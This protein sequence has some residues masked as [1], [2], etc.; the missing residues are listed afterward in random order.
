MKREHY[1]ELKYIS[2]RLKRIADQIHDVCSIPSPGNYETSYNR[3]LLNLLQE[4]TE[5]KFDTFKRLED[6]ILKESG[7]NE[8]E[9]QHLTELDHEIRIANLFISVKLELR[10]QE[11]RAENSH[12]IKCFYCESKVHYV[13]SCLGFE[14]LSVHRRC[15]FL[16]EN[17]ICFKCLR[18]HI[19]PNCTK[20][21]LCK[22]CGKDNH[23]TLVHRLWV[24]LI[25]YMIEFT[26]VFDLLSYKIKALKAELFTIL[27]RFNRKCCRQYFCCRLLFNEVL[28][29]FYNKR[30]VSCR[31]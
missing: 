30:I 10:T 28:C 22:L 4:E 24:S 9:I 1:L 15:R 27:P 29:W 3:V 5:E 26:T 20:E 12:D 16:S 13:S 18:P 23:H 2:L 31:V 6:E 7:V 19:D 14:N 17:K 11:K 25:L 21:V 8:S